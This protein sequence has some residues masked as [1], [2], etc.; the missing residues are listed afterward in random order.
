MQQDSNQHLLLADPR[1]PCGL[2]EATCPSL[3]ADLS[4]KW[5]GPVLVAGLDV[6]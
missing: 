1:N 5:Q 4:H 6:S 3:L 2:S